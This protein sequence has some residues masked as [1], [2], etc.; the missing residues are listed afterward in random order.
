MRTLLSLFGLI[1]GLPILVAQTPHHF[2]TIVGVDY[3]YRSDN[4]GPR[5][6][7][8]S[9]NLHLRI[10]GDYSRELTSFLH[11]RTGARLTALGYDSGIQQLVGEVSDPYQIDAGLSAFSDPE[12]TAGWY[13]RTTDFYLEI[14]LVFRY[15]PENSDHFYVEGGL[16]AY[17]YLKTYFRSNGHYG[18]KTS[19]DISRSAD[20]LISVLQASAGWEWPISKEAQ[21]YVQPIFRYFLTDNNSFKMLSG[22]L[23]TGVRW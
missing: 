21:F 15:Q 19:W 18:E 10:G 4:L 3:L 5:F 16:A 11:L 6:Y 13:F 17:F 8:E 23:E 22:G 1:I 9:P 2:S 14:P 7:G 20:E 12:T